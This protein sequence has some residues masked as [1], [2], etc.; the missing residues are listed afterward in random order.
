MVLRIM[1]VQNDAILGGEKILIVDDL[2]A[3][4]GTAV[5]AASLVEKLGGI[6]VGFVFIICLNYLDGMD[7]LKNHG[8]DV[9]C[10]LE[11]D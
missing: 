8:Y 7:T 2:L 6:V 10:I 11:Y 3:T 9:N 5:A 1:E 4:G